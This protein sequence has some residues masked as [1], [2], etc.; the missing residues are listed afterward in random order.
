LGRGV[1]R[2]AQT[3]SATAFTVLMA[4][5]MA[6]LAASAN[7][8]DSRAALQV[9]N[10]ERDE[11]QQMIGPFANTLLVR[12]PVDR[13]VH[14]RAFLHTVHDR[15][16]ETYEHQE[17][18]FDQVLAAIDDGIEVDVARLLQVGFALHDAFAQEHSVPDGT[19]RSVSAEDPESA[20][21]SID[22]TTFELVL[23]LRPRGD[24]F[25]GEVTYESE[26]Y[27]ET[28]VAAFADSYLRF[29]ALVVADPELA[30]GTA[31][32]RAMGAVA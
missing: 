3:E 8:T 7:S 13:A 25:A 9:A 23:E 27:P 19:L 29:L 28:V 24:G 18:P 26:L 12:A 2:L 31:H 16:L 20:E 21:E 14:F 10:R 15:A 22:A 1:S 17:V 5:F 4:A 32:D 30:V 11:T 6:V